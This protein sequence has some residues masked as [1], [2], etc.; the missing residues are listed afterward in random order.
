MKWVAKSSTYKSL[1][2]SSDK[3]SKDAMQLI[4]TTQLMVW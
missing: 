1:L 4:Q 2:L 3:T